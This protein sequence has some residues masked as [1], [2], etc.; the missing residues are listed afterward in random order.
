MCCSWGIKPTFVDVKRDSFLIDEQMIYEAITR[1][2]KQLYTVDI[3][4]VPVTTI[5]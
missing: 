5:C 1:K 4:G 2:P 3:A